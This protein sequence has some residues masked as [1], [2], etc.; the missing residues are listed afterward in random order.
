[1]KVLMFPF[2]DKIIAKEMNDFMIFPHTDE[3]IAKFAKRQTKI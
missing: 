1:M 2:N 3:M